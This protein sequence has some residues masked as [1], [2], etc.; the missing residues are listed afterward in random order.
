[1]KKEDTKNLSVYSPLGASNHSTGER[2]E[3][4]YYASDPA[5]IRCLLNECITPNHEIW[6]PACGE[7]HLSK[8]LIKA[9]FHVYSTDLY[10]RGYGDGCV[11][12][13]TCTEKWVGDIV[14]N[15]PYKFAQEFVEHALDLIDDGNRVYMLL[16]LTFLEGKKRRELFDRRLLEKVYVFTNRITC[17]KNGVFP[18]DRGAVAYAWFVFRKGY[19]D[20]PEIRWIN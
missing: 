5:A 19:N 12:F 17:G 16:K 10:D 8:E 11:D 14:T 3:N 6:E 7:G 15:P 2:E 4:D 1:M 9:G 18:K 20:F 13:L